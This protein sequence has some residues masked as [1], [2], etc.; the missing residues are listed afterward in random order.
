VVLLL[1]IGLPVITNTFSALLGG[2]HGDHHYEE[3]NPFGL[4]YTPYAELV[5]AGDGAAAE[6]VEISLGC[7]LAEADAERGARSAGICASCHSFDKG[8]PQGTGPN[9]WDVVN[10][11]IGSVDAYG[12]YSGAL[13]AEEGVWS[14]DK[15]DGYLYDSQSYINGTQMAQ[16]IRKDGKRADILAYLGTLKDG[17]PAEYP[18]CEPPAEEGEAMAEGEEETPMEETAA[19]AADRTDFEVPDP[20]ETTLPDSNV[21]NPGDD[22]YPGDET[23]ENDYRSSGGD[24]IEYDRTEDPGAPGNEDALPEGGTTSGDS[25]DSPEPD[26]G[27]DTEQ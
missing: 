11:D 6:E 4:S 23:R 18:V 8:G 14:Y 17:E 12:G 25:P 5:G 27:E 2:H 16:K 21:N 3:E 19:K 24:E 15:L 22:G 13:K 26:G 7:L 9:L 20:G 1:F 10:R